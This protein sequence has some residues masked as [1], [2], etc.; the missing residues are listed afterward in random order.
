[1]LGLGA[2]PDG[3]DAKGVSALSMAAS[4]GHVELVEVVLAAGANIKSKT[5]SG[6]T[7]LMLAA[8]SGKFV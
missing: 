4:Y 1:M 6:A 2:D 7:A 8:T 5:K 3:R